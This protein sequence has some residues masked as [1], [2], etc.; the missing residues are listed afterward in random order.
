M[1]SA[2]R[3][4]PHVSS[5]DENASGFTPAPVNPRRYDDRLLEPDEATSIIVNMI[6]KGARVLDVG[7]AA[8]AISQLIADKCHAEVVGVEP[9][10]DRA[11]LAASRGLNV[12]VGTL[13][14]S[15][16]SEIGAF[17]IVLFS[18]VLEHLPN[19]QATLLLAR[20]VL[21]PGAYAVVSLPNVAHW[22][23]RLEILQGRFRYQECGIMDA[24][25][26][27]W[28]TRASAISLL[29]SAGFRVTAYN[30]SLGAGLP[31]NTRRRPMSW[32]SDNH[33]LA[34]LQWGCR[35]WP[36]LFGAQHIFKAEMLPTV[37]CQK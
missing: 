22:S 19:P 17:D 37:P 13:E 2:P 31:D 9:D 30:V 32:L 10:P 14:P 27:K 20:E 15:L 8:G 26:L 35:H 12:H 24:T 3:T 11:A 6:P 23:V 18:D 33:R 5:P 1:S 28:F 16:I 4:V 25:H 29:E 7:C 36:T 34:L 21:R